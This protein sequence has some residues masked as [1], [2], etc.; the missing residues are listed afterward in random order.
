MESRIS[1][2]D[3]FTRVTLREQQRRHHTHKTAIAKQASQAESIMKI[4]HLYGAQNHDLLMAKH[5]TKWKHQVT[6]QVTICG[7]RAM[8]S[9][10][11]LVNAELAGA[12]LMIDI[13]C[14]EFYQKHLKQLEMKC[15]DTLWLSYCSC[16]TSTTLIDDWG[17]CFDD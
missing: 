5:S 11:N 17:M 4:M 13:L 6:T 14:L 15:S 8:A 16:Y 9:V 1:L 10:R 7:T 2:Y 3:S 12:L